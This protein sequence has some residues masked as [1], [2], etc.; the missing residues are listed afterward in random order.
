MQGGSTLA[1]EDPSALQVKAVVPTAH[2]RSLRR[3]P[4]LQKLQGPPPKSG[5]HPTVP[6]KAADPAAAADD[7]DNWRNWRP[8]WTAEEWREWHQT[9]G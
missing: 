3:K 2:S 9:R 8:R 5:F 4:R 7:D 1:P 6:P